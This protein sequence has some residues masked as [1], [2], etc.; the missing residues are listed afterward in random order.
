MQWPPESFWNLCIGYIDFFSFFLLS[1]FLCLLLSLWLLWCFLFSSIGCTGYLPSSG[2]EITLGFYCSCI[3]HICNT[4]LRFSFFPCGD[5]LCL[6][7][8][9]I[10]QMQ[11]YYESHTLSQ[12]FLISCLDAGKF[13]ILCPWQPDYTEEKTASVSCFV[14]TAN[15]L[16]VSKN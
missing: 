1:F 16:G 11:F 9:L 14:P 13:L 2:T 4:F 6:H 15:R 10:Q 12:G 8:L 5:G 3:R 7:S